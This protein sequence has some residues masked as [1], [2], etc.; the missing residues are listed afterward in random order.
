MTNTSLPLICFV[1]YS[2]ERSQ[3]ASPRASLINFLAPALDSALAEAMFA[4]SAVNIDAEGVAAS[5]QDVV[6]YF[7]M[8]KAVSS[9]SFLLV[10]LSAKYPGIGPVKPCMKNLNA[11][12][13]AKHFVTT[14]GVCSPFL[15]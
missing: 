14:Q 9:A 10:A 15:F 5:G 2:A 6:A 11:K 3:V 1:K 8:N 12:A 7:E 13:L 4:G